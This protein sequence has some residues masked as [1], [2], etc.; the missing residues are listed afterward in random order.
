MQRTGRLML[1]IFFYTIWVCLNNW[2]KQ[3]ITATGLI[4]VKQRKF[5]QA[6]LTVFF[7]N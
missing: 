1:K 7:F 2:K 5:D 3:K 4:V 6:T